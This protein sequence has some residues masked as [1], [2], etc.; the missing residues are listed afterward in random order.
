M[1]VLPTGQI[2]F[3]DFSNDIEIFTPTKGHPEHSEPVVTSAPMFLHDG[4]S[5]RIFGFRL[6]G[7][8]QGAA[9]GDDI[10]GATNYPL[11][12]L[13]NLINGHV[14]Y[15]R[16]H[17]HSS[18]AVASNDLVSTHFDVPGDQEPCICRLEV[19]ANGIASGPVI[20]F[21]GR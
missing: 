4:G 6:N 10:Q 14:R 11:V 7:M 8:S 19:V 3:T 20:V 5:Y 17:D 9:Y 2:L 18:M 15:S 16:T 1:L 21:V 13:T 12:R